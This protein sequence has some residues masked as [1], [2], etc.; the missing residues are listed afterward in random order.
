[1]SP[2]TFHDREKE[3]EEITRILKSPPNLITFVYGPINSGKTELFQ[4]LIKTLSKE[5]R[6]FYVNLRGVYVSKAEDLLTVLFNVEEKEYEFKEFLKVLIDYL[7]DKIPP[8]GIP[9][10]KNFFKKFFEERGLDN[11]FKYLER[12]FVELSSEVTPILVLDELQV[13]GDLKVDDLLIYKLFNLFVR[14]TKELHSCHVFAVTSDSLFIEKIFNEA[15]LHGRCRYLLV[16]DFDYETTAEFL[17]KHGFDEDE[18]QLTW[19]YFGGKPV[20]L[21]EAVNNRDRLKELCESWLRL[22]KRQIKDA[23]YGLNEDSRK[24]VL[25]ALSTFKEKEV[26]SYEK[27]TDELV[28]CIKNNILFL[29]PM[30]E[31]LKPQSR[32]DLLAI[33]SILRERQED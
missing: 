9:T 2:L 4:H 20:Y 31:I 18:I 1:M 8:I 26:I 22:R 6:A 10:P 17:R 16:D 11:A 14:L 33:R 13:I 3:I 19:D 7:P 29:D 24:S 5:Y 12:L 15:M 27:I 28:W 30:N 23:L 32:L 25:K 21:V